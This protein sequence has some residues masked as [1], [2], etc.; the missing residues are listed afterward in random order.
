MSID[1]EI[2]TYEKL[3]D[4]SR[5]QRL[6]YLKNHENIDRRQQEL[7]EQA[8]PFVEPLV[9]AIKQQRAKPEQEALSK[10]QLR[11]SVNA[12][13]KPFPDRPKEFKAYLVDVYEDERYFNTLLSLVKLNVIKDFP[14]NA[15]KTHGLVNSFIFYGQGGT[16]L[17]MMGVRSQ[18]LKDRLASFQDFFNKN[19]NAL[20]EIIGESYVREE[21]F[22]GDDFDSD[23]EQEELDTDDDSDDKEG[24]F[25]QLLDESP[26]LLKYGDGYVKDLKDELKLLLSAKD[27]GN[28]SLH[29]AN[30]ASDILKKLLKRGKITKCKYKQISKEFF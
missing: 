28:T 22:D 21:E 12:V 17:N 11:N 3:A 13:S 7:Q 2:E 27:A 26:S 23:D 4:A 25:T 24:D 15:M 20:R 30:K 1:K 14:I 9:E 6:Q 29:N 8:Q 16:N 5:Q 10:R 19:S 18:E